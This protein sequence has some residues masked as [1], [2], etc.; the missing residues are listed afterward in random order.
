V[1][2]ID[3]D[4]EI[5]KQSGREEAEGLSLLKEGDHGGHSFDLGLRFI[6]A[7][8]RMFWYTVQKEQRVATT[9]QGIIKMFVCYE[10]ILNEKQGPLS[11]QTSLLYFFKTSS[12]NRASSPVSLY[13][14]NE[15][16]L[17]PPTTKKEVPPR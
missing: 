3:D 4:V 16:P 5:R 2:T 10:K 11:R 7:G 17:G 14:A 8:I 9:R 1:F 12:R 6:T 13:V 15:D